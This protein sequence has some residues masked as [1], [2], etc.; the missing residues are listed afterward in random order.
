MKTNKRSTEHGTF[1]YLEAA[2]TVVRLAGF[3]FQKTDSSQ[4]NI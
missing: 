1:Q 2:T 3:S 4:G